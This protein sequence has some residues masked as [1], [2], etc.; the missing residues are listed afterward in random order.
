VPCIRLSFNVLKLLLQ[1]RI[2]VASKL[3]KEVGM[4]HYTVHLL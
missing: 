2:P 1:L 4:V 3:R